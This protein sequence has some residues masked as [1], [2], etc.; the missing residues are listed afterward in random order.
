MHG[1]FST[2]SC[3]C[4]FV[5]GAIELHS[6]FSETPNMSSGS[7][8]TICLFFFFAETQWLYYHCPPQYSLLYWAFGFLYWCEKVAHE[9]ELA[10]V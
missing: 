10:I 2:S 1:S 3:L 4:F 9:L 5:T 6:I 8:L 7:D